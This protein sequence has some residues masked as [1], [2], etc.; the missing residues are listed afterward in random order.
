MIAQTA[1]TEMKAGWRRLILQITGFC[2]GLFLITTFIKNIEM[3][4]EENFVI[5]NAN[6]AFPW[7]EEGILNSFDLAWLDACI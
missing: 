1:N 3:L 4:K 2:C 6:R 7:G 5:S